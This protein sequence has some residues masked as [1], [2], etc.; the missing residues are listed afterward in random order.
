VD[1]RR[2]DT[3]I[4]ISGSEKGQTGRVLWIDRRKQRVVVE[5]LNMIKRHTR[6]R[7]Q[8]Q[9]QSGIIEKEA[10]M[11]ISNVALYDPKAKGPTR[12]KYRI[13]YET[14]GNRKVKVRE[15]ISVRSGEVLEPPTGA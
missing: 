13:R 8:Q 6:P 15:R 12:V 5:K 14:D 2:G 4:V 3:V 9:Q 11:H 10:P 1:I 7:S